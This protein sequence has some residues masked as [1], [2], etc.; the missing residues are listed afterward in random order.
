MASFSY[1]FSCSGTST[2]SDVLSLNVPLPGKVRALVE[3]LRPALGGFETIREEPTLVAKRFGRLD[4]DTAALLESEVRLALDDAPPFEARVAGLGAFEEPPT[5]PAPVVYLTVESPGLEA[6][7]GRLVDEFGAVE[8]LEGPHYVPHLT[9]AR[10]GDVDVDEVV[11]ELDV[12]P[13]T[14]TVTELL[15]WD[16]RHGERAGRV[17]LPA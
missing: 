17:S 12:E 14:W 10:G 9:L 4:A 3:R 13:V 7:H 16:A 2:T 15:I 5:G 11:E 6:L 1:W 8:G